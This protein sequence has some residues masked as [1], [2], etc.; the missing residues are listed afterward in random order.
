MWVSVSW[1]VMWLSVQYVSWSVMWLSVQ[2]VSLSAFYIVYMFRMWLRSLMFWQDISIA[3][4]IRCWKREPL[5]HW[6]LMR[7]T[8]S[9]SGFSCHLMPL[10]QVHLQ[11]CLTSHISL[12][13]RSSNIT[14]V[15]IFM[16]SANFNTILLPINITCNIQRWS[17]TMKIWSYPMQYSHV[18]SLAMCAV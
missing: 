16:A 5:L 1:S 10:V 12:S 13:L 4:V 18:C 8:A 14:I 15:E 3:M 9:Q 6:V 7:C 17:A 11:G 2:Y